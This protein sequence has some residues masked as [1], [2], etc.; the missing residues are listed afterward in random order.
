MNE[1]IPRLLREAWQV[2][3]QGTWADVRRRRFAEIV[4]YARA[5]SPYYRD[6][7]AGLP[8]DV[9]DPAA[10]PVTDKNELMAHYDSWCTDPA[11]TYA[12]V[13]AF[14]ADPAR[15]GERFRDRYL[16]VTTSGTTGH[17]GIFVKDARDIA[18]NG[19]LSGR[20]M[21]SWLGAGDV[22]RIAA[23]A[24]RMAIVAATNGHFLVSAGAARM[25][26]GRLGQHAVRL[27][28][29]HTPLPELVAE[30]NAFRPAV[31]LGYGGVL[32]MLAEE[33]EAGRLAIA[34]VLVEPAGETLSEADH[35]RMARAFGAKVR[36][37]YGASE[38][39]YLTDGCAH[40]WYHVNADW[41]V[42]EPVNADHSPTPP[43]EPSHTVLI[44]NLAN[45]VQP[46]LRYDLGDSVMQRPDPCPCGNPMPAVRVQGR[47]ANVLTFAGDAGPVTIPPL[48]LNTLVDGVPGTEQYQIVQ[49]GRACLRVR[50]RVAPDA[51]ADRVW[52]GVRAGIARLLAGRGLGH[53]TLERATEPPEQ[54]P[55]G[56]YRPVIPLEASA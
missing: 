54:A 29:V 15:A 17:P 13:G 44:S 37:T 50:L 55:G 2:R 10:L 51:S 33:R 30:L 12:D 42:L 40:G 14:V 20:M 5:R 4:A 24:G 19:A 47:V 41:A 32:R 8:A 7:Y 38:C 34:P 9:R 25:R 39:P 52:E 6:L 11:V 3:R 22:A 27:F 45:R 18:V 26:G 23:H 21:A 56:K 16:V 48:I 53:V 35:A 46:I 49:T 43:G 28:S 1:G 31:L 36:D